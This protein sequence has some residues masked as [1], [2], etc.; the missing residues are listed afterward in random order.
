MREISLEREASESI[1]IAGGQ[2]HLAVPQKSVPPRSTGPRPSQTLCMLGRRKQW[3]VTVKVGLAVFIIG[4]AVPCVCISS[5]VSRGGRSNSNCDVPNRINSSRTGFVSPST[6]GVRSAA[7]SARSA[8]ASTHRWL[9]QGGKSLA[10]KVERG[11][12]WQKHVLV[13]YGM[14]RDHDD[15]GFA[16]APRTSDAGAVPE[17]K[18]GGE[19]SDPE[20]KSL[21][22][23][24][25]LLHGSDNPLWE[26]VRFEVGEPHDGVCL[27]I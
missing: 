6:G 27:S 10:G 1:H 19:S 15:D 18:G 24:V 12:P 20:V 11:G 25:N 7:A 5:C 13:R 21:V 17:G 8:S 16:A 9:P 3:L 14:S 4:Y 23:L 26:L 2:P 22:D